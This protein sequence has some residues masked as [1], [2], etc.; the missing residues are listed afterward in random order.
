VIFLAATQTLTLSFGNDGY[1]NT[2]RNSHPVPKI[3]VRSQILNNLSTKTLNF[4]RSSYVIDPQWQ[5]K[6]TIIWPTVLG[7]FVLLSLPHLIRSIRNGHAYS[8]IWGIWEDYTRPDYMAI[9]RPMLEGER[10][11]TSVLYRTENFIGKFGSLFYWTL[12][13]LGLNAGQRTSF[14]LLTKRKFSENSSIVA[15]IIG[16]VVTAVLC[17]VLDAPLISN[18]NR[19]GTHF[20]VSHIGRC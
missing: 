11:R 4:P 15:I 19:A 2:A 5:R 20:I 10:K 16:Y 18:S 9:V 14:Y 8:T 13:G 7:F 12:P 3:Q 6:F 1:R 17:I